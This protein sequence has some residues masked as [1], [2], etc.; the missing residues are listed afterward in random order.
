MRLRIILL[1]VRNFLDGVRPI[2]TY[3]SRLSVRRGTNMGKIVSVFLSILLLF[4]LAMIE[5]MLAFNYLTYQTLGSFANIPYLGMFLA[6]L[7]GFLMLFFFG[8]LGLS[9]VIFRGKDIPSLMVL[10]VSEG[11]LL[12]SRLLIAYL[13]YAPL[14]WAVVVPGIVVAAFVQG[15]GGLFITA[16]LLLLLLGPLIP[17]SLALVVSSLLV[18]FTKGKRFKLV[19]QLVSFVFIMGLI[20]AMT[21]SLTVNMVDD[22]FFQ[23]DYQALMNKA[24]Q[25]FVTLTRHLVLFRIQAFMFWSTQELLGHVILTLGCTCLVVV[26]L[27]KRYGLFL[28]LVASRESVTR[29]K[30]KS[31]PL[32]R[33]AVVP[34]LMV[35]EFEILQSHSAFMFETVGELLIPFILAIVYAITG[36]LGELSQAVSYISL[37]PYL[38][39]GLFLGIHVV[40]SIS[41]LSS[42][43]VS[44][45][46]KQFVMDKILPLEAEV[47]VKAKIALHLLLVGVTNILYLCIALVSFSLSLLHLFWMIPLSAFILITTASYGLALDYKRPLLDWTLAQQAMKNNLNGVLAMLTSLGVLI[48]LAGALLTPIILFALPL[49]GIALAFVLAIILCFHAYRLCLTQASRALSR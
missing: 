9:S 18:Y 19:E 7:A 28:S 33:R 39:Y 41:M 43:S 20:M 30:G 48:L 23:I 4:S 27:S 35:R 16:S 14:Y 49:A 1:L 26:L 11:E 21:R 3:F 5:I 12:T 40:G 32:R 38:P 6:S 34:T 8:S 15:V 37:S 47:F 31:V 10:P 46:G 36:L 25:P 2:R 22:S 13:L 17:L 24:I 44:R 29:K 42:T 45:Q